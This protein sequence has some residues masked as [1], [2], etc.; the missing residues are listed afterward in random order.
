MENWVHKMVHREVKP[1]QWAGA[2]YALLKSLAMVYTEEYHNHNLATVRKKDWKAAKE[3]VGKHL[4]RL[5][6]WSKWNMAF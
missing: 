4:R 5:P 3:K 6:E 1:E 2:L